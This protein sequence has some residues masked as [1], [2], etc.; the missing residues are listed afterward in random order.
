MLPK[1]C[2][3]TVP[4]LTLTKIPRFPQK[5][6]DLLVA[7]LQNASK[8]GSCTSIFQSL[9]SWQGACYYSRVTESSEKDDQ[10]YK[11]DKGVETMNAMKQIARLFKESKGVATSLV[12]ATATIAV[13]AV[14][15]GAA[16]TTGLDAIEAA[17]V[18]TT[19]EQVKTIG[20]AVLTFYQDNG[21]Y[22]GYKVGTVTGPA[23]TT[24]AKHFVNLV[25]RNGNYPTDTSGTGG[26]GGVGWSVGSTPAS[27]PTIIGSL[28]F[29]RFGHSVVADSDAIENHLQ[30][31][32][33]ADSAAV[34]N[35]YPARGSGAFGADSTRGWNGPYPADGIPATDSWGGKFLINVTNLNK[36][37]AP[38][39]GNTAVFVISAGTNRTLET[40]A[41][42]LIGSCTGCVTDPKISGDDIAFRVR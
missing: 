29:D 16:V 28:S 40:K 13:G 7:D 14:L 32:T 17:R 25:S 3:G 23:D 31:N 2:A 37:N 24:S 5:I 18:E 30:T 9:R 19:K 36:T 26:T 10:F 4:L 12:E 8:Q 15:A 11:V 33:P 42:Q 6:V 20:L 1:C 41:D 38:A 27:G 39:V 34:A 21:V 35:K 22:P